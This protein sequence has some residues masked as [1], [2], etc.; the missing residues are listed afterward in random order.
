MVAGCCI[1]RI[2][3]VYGGNVAKRIINNKKE[4]DVESGIR[5]IVVL[6]YYGRWNT[7]NEVLNPRR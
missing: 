5:A 1:V 3:K 2:N 4:C 7:T 6:R